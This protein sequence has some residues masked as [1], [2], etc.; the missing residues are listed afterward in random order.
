MSS[1]EME[2]HT[3]AIKPPRMVPR[4]NDFV[5]VPP[6]GSRTISMAR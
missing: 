5:M 6:Y 2:L 3:K 1:H 4:I